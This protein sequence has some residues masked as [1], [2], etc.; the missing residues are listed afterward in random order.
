V[1]PSV[2]AHATVGT[3]V[4]LYDQA[5]GAL[6]DGLISQDTPDTLWAQTADD[7]VVPAGGWTVTAVDMVVID[8]A[9]GAG[10][11]A[12]VS[13]Y[14]DNA[15]FPAD[16]AAFHFDDVAFEA[17]DIGDAFGGDIFSLH[18][19]LPSN[20]GLTAGTWWVSVQVDGTAP[21][22]YTAMSD[23]DTFGSRPAWREAGGFGSPC[24]NTWGRAEDCS[25]A[26]MK[27]MTFTIYGPGAPT[28]SAPQ[29]SIADKPASSVEGNTTDGAD[30]S[31]GTVSVTD[32][33]DSDLVPACSD[34]TDDVSSGDFF[35]LGGPYTVTCSATDS[36]DLSGSDSFTFS[37][38]DT[39]KPTLDAHDD[40]LAFASGASQ[41]T[42][43][44][45]D[46]TAT[47]I[48]DDSP[49]VTC[50]PASGATFP[51]GTTQVSCTATDGSSNTSDAQTF[52]VVVSYDFDGFFSPVHSTVDPTSGATP[53]ASAD[54][55][56]SAKA[57]SAI[58]VKFSLGGDQGKPVFA[59]G[60]PKSTQI[61]C[62]PGRMKSTSV[63]GGN[64]ARTSGL[65]Y[66]TL[67]G[68]YTYTWKT[69]VAGFAGTCRRLE[70]PLRD[71]TSRFAFFKF[72]K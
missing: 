23:N 38:V 71:G 68:V 49:A 25:D 52:D 3:D 59:A 18:L 26:G 14:P 27:A 28:N 34:G 37:V 55:W 70:L 6:I 11:T 12:D 39:T 47:D 33:N 64:G 30:V 15:G 4:V 9:G 5:P 58:P 2:A 50:L 62:P 57:G 19:P 45:D 65:K 8:V 63:G 46:P 43:T 35:A 67:S 10:S 51:L 22:S 60:G 1:L 66:D 20:A 32:D 44:Y 36:G 42:V 72:T 48:V 24:T 61:T 29:V 56:N 53:A 31:W 40:V 54:G 41:A 69:S 7:F 21:S 13:L 17:T 16:D